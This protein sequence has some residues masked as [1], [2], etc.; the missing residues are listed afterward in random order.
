MIKDAKHPLVVVKREDLL[1]FFL[2]F[3]CKLIS[4][5]FGLLV[6][7]NNTSEEINLGSGKLQLAFFT[8]FFLHF[9]A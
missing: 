2:M 4:L 6:E 8:F 9:I 7:Q 1:L 5:H 3:H